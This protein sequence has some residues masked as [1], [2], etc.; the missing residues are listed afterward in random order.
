MDHRQSLQHVSE[1]Q[2]PGEAGGEQPRQARQEGGGERAGED[3]HERV[4]QLEGIEI[5]PRPERAARGVDDQPRHPQIE[6]RDGQP[7]DGE[8]GRQ[9]A[10]EHAGEAGDGL[11]GEEL[12]RRGSSSFKALC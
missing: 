2:R 11:F 9:R 10:G 5:R 1:E 12:C 8:G 7:D 6:Q 3:E 4:G